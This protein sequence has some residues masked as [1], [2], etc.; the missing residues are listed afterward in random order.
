MKFS[1]D[2]CQ[3][4]NRNATEILRE[5]FIWKRGFRKK[6]EMGWTNKKTGNT[7]RNIRQGVRQR[8]EMG[9]REKRLVRPFVWFMMVQCLCEEFFNR[10]EYLLNGGM[11]HKEKRAL[12]YFIA[13]CKT[14]IPL[15]WLT[16]QETHRTNIRSI[17]WD[18]KLEKNT[19]TQTE[20]GG[21]HQTNA[22]DVFKLNFNQKVKLYKKCSVV[23]SRWIWITLLYRLIDKYSLHQY[24]NVLLPRKMIKTMFNIHH[25]V[26]KFFLC[27]L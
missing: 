13:S 17:S 19:Q 5:F 22:T 21:K 9:T 15:L 20:G 12:Q 6:I 11:R 23:P 10:C 14:V 3:T 24:I 27:V 26:E 7:E 4:Y 2:Y 18:K 1:V 25:F 16:P 8:E